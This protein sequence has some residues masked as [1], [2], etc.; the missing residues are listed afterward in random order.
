[1]RSIGTAFAEKGFDGASMQ[2]LAR[3]AG[4]SVGNFYR[5][6]P[7]KDAIVEAMVSYDMAE[8]ERDFAA[9]LSSDDPLA[10]IRAKITER[11]N[12]GCAEDGPPLGRDHR[13]RPSQA[14][15]RP[16]LLRDGRTGGRKPADGLCPADRGLADATVQRYGAHARFI[17]MMVK[18]AAMRKRDAPDPDLTAL[19]LRSI[20]ATLSE[21]LDAARA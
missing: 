3:A 9:I 2:D 14:R 16:H 18:A 4:M 13:R 21:I 17:V 12:N 11:L 15:N 19:I 20:D 8:M 5:Y 1:M 10:G 7:S 6:F